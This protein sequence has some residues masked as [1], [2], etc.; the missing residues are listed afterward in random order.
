M[1]LFAITATIAI[2]LSANPVFAQTR[3]SEAPPSLRADSATIRKALDDKAADFWI[4]E[5]IKAGF[6][7]SRRTGKPILLSIR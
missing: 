7:E 5:D 2:I 6:E 3:G 1:R 4:Y